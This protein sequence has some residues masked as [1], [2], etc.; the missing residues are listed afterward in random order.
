V[1]LELLKVLVQPVALERDAE[2]RIVGE[3]VGEAT[4]LFTPEQL[5]EFVAE[6][7]RQIEAANQNGTG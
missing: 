4:A 1:S 5:S 6:L 2:G 7:R 3:K